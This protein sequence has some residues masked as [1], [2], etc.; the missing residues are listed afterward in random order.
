MTK[1]FRSFLPTQARPAADRPVERL[2][3]LSVAAGIL[4][5]SAVTI[6]RRVADGSLTP[7]R[8][9][10]RLDFEPGELRAFIALHR[11]V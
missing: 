2:I 10:G 5:V 8:V 6:R 9:N 4:G 11:E 1:T 7:V 3:K